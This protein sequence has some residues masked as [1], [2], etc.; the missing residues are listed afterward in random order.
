MT[1][2]ELVAALLDKDRLAHEQEDAN[3]PK[4]T[5]GPVILSPDQMAAV[6]EMANL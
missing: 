6:D 1:I 5:Q 3:Q 2:A 4:P